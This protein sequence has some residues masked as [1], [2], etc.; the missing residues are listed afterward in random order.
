MPEAP[1]GLAVYLNADPDTR[2]SQEGEFTNPV[3]V[4]IDGKTGSTIQQRLYV[5]NDDSDLSYS[6][7]S[8]TPIST[9]LGIT[10]A[11]GELSLK[12]YP[13]NNQPSEDQWELVSAGNTISVS[14]VLGTDE[15]GDTTT[16][17]PFWM[18]VTSPRN[19]SVQTELGVKL[20][21]QAT[22]ILVV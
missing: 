5:R 13:G 8:V 11:A 6:G 18:R 22:E 14:G 1:I 19:M 20:E 4:I 21:V 12:L 17:L 16:Y 10:G 15:L 9:G 7:I 3:N 2:V